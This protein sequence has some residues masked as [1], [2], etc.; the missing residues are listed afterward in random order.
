MA[1]PRSRPLERKEPG[2]YKRGNRYVV[3]FRDQLGRQRK[4]AAATLAE[5]R[6]LRATLTADVK[7]GEYRALSRVTFVEYAPT[8]WK[9]YN[10]RTYR[11][12]GA[13]T[14][15]DYAEALG[16]DP[17][18]GEPFSPV[19][20]AIKFFGRM[21]MSEIE[22]MHVKQ[23]A[24]QLA[25]AGLAPASVAKYVSPVRA[26]FADAL[27]E[28][29]IRVNPADGLRLARRR[30]SD[31]GEDLDEGRVKALSEDELERFLGAV[32]PKWRLFF[33]FLSESGLR[34]GE[35][36][37]LRHG[38][39]EGCWVNVAR[40]YSDGNVGLPKGRKT[41][42]IRLTEEMGRRL[43]QLRRGAAAGD[44]VF[45]SER[46]QR[47]N[48]SNLMTR[49]LKP[50][51]VAAGLGEWVKTPDGRRAESWIGFHTFR[52]TTA[53]RLFRGYRDPESGA[54]VG[55]W[56]AAQVS[57]FLGHTDPG[58]TLRTYVHL[59]P[60]DLPEPTFGPPSRGS[61]GAT[62]PTETRR[63]AEAGLVAVSA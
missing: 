57:K 32:D 16:I 38:D 20:G 35:A 23:Y 56:N 36:I 30:M 48:P 14:K 53:T 37:E 44:V 40:R 2:I 21:R 5:A 58:F 7:R 22:L 8:W 47:I 17:K 10:G 9:T 4:Q 46:G 55:G 1:A 51:A 15:Q 61:N 29:V 27:G 26:L 25:D 45:T 13:G 63:N 31:G 12:V 59:L 60:E 41:R 34:I 33:E 19:R 42:R 24:A 54:Y 28:R 52:H 3:I 62:N 18:T 11:G 50:A 6:T 49:V 39:V 43:W